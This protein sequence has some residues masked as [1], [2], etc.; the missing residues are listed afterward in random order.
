MTAIPDA[1]PDG[2]ACHHEC[3]PSACFRVRSCGPLSIAQ[4]P[5]DEWPLEILQ[6]HG[7]RLPEVKAFDTY[8]TN[9]DLIEAA[10]RLGYLR[11]EWSTLDPTWGEGVFWRKWR[12]DHLHGT[13]LVERKGRAAQEATGSFGPRQ[14]DVRRLPFGNESWDAVVFDGPYKFNGKPDAETDERYGVHLPT[15]WQ[16]RMDLLIDGTRECARV[17][18]IM[19]LV[20]CQ[21]QV[22]SGK[23]RWQTR[24]LTEAAEALGF[25]LVAEM[26]KE[27]GRP[28]PT[29]RPCSACRGK[30]PEETKACPKCEG[31][32]AIPVVQKTPTQNFSTL[33]VLRRG[34]SWRHDLI[35][36]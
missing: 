20:K 25:G 17:A 7:A 18:R 19:L 14:A 28:Q 29:T 12:P 26:H 34:H 32:M 11:K 15:R 10:A 30:T 35:R 22:V 31:A 33:L 8:T 1:C 2:G 13:D 5:D 16:D 9:A 24:V 3:E 4:Y 36:G 23:R 6:E 21:D 27:G